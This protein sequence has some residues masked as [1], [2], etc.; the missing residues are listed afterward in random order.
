MVWCEK[1]GA[2]EV[3]RRAQSRLFQPWWT[4]WGSGSRIEACRF[5]GSPKLEVESG[6]GRREASSLFVERQ[7]AKELAILAPRLSTMAKGQ[8]ASGKNFR[9]GDLRSS[10]VQ[11]GLQPGSFTPFGNNMSLC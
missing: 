9:R 2:Q 3:L 11:W 1:I 8:L 10:C 6:R 7:V 5:F 4:L